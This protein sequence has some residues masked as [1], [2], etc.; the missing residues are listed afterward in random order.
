MV[1]KEEFDKVVKRCGQTAVR[2]AI[3]TRRHERLN[4]LRHRVDDD[5]RSASEHAY[6]L[7]FD[8]SY[9]PENLW[10]AYQGVSEPATVPHQSPGAGDTPRRGEVGKSL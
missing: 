9:D 3:Q 5:L 7:L 6:R 2:E 10:K 8:R 4:N 1:S